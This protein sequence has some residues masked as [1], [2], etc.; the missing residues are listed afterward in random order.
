MTD[1]TPDPLTPGQDDAVRRL[2][3]SARHSDPAPP[4]VVARLDE[5]LAS[6][7]SERMQAPAPIVT[8]ASRRRRTAATALL[9]A[10]AV[11]VLGVGIGQVL[12]SGTSTDAGSS[13]GAGDS[14]ASSDERPATAESGRAL[15]AESDSAADAEEKLSDLR[16]QNGR[17]TGGP[18]ALTSDSG[19]R[20]Q[21]RALRRAS[22]TAAYS[23]GPLCTLA[24]ARSGERVPVTF[25]GVPAVLVF[26]APVADRQRV[27]LFLCGE[28]VPTRSVRLRAR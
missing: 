9:A 21:V 23:S 20:S 17:K 22:P 26:R 4:E 11:V 7:R 25:D 19:L 15:D 5:T 28:T 16:M 14:A 24:D 1:P 27:D 18:G 3:A 12:P 10:A 8:L 6:L 13:A 2:L